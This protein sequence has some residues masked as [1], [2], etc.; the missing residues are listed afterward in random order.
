MQRTTQHSFGAGWIVSWDQ[1]QLPLQ[2]RFKKPCGCPQPWRNRWLHVRFESQKMDDLFARWPLQASRVQTHPQALQLV[3]SIA[4]FVFSEGQVEVFG[5][6]GTSST[7]ERLVSFC[8]FL[9]HAWSAT[10][11]AMSFIF[12]PEHC[13]ESESTLTQ[14]PWVCESPLAQLNGIHHERLQ[15]ARTWDLGRPGK[16]HVAPMSR[17]QRGPTRIHKSDLQMWWFAEHAFHYHAH[18]SQEVHL[19][20]IK[21]STHHGDG[22]LLRRVHSC[23]FLFRS[24]PPGSPSTPEEWEQRFKTLLRSNNSE[25]PW[26]KL[27]IWRFPKIG[28]S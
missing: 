26:L 28:V 9:C 11:I 21:I 13:H 24:E 10:H 23:G 14:I 15:A 1:N 8:G 6:F 16:F 18:V 20:M 3:L 7:V 22:H 17:F 4:L 2:E 12:K 19:W 5:V 25:F 27:I